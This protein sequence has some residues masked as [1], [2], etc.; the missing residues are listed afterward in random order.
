MIAGDGKP[1]P[2]KTILFELFEPILCC[3]RCGSPGRKKDGVKSSIQRW[4]CKDCG[5]GYL[6]VYNGHSPVSDS[7]RVIAARLLALDTAPL[8][9]AT[10]L[11]VSVQWVYGFRRRLFKRYGDDLTGII[12]GDGANNG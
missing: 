12:K 4:V 10:A 6:D 11:Q 3:P 1:E 7:H 5:R 8:V 2:V 9:V